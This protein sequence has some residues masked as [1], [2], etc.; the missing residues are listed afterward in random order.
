L[1][2]YYAEIILHMASHLLQQPLLPD[3]ALLLFERCAAIVLAV[4]RSGRGGVYTLFW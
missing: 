1:K 3:P 4:Y 2:L